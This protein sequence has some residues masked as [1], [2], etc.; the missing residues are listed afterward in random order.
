MEL[1]ALML[2]HIVSNVREQLPAPELD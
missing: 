2:A 1:L